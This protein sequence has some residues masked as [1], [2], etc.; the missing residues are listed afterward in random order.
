[1]YFEVASVLVSSETQ[2]QSQILL[3]PDY[4]PHYLSVSYD[5]GDSKNNVQKR[6]DVEIFILLLSLNNTEI[7]NDATFL[8]IFSVETRNIG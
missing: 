1:M 5:Y 2:V 3:N 7:S 4:L 8:T 6:N